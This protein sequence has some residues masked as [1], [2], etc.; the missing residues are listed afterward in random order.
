M[1][2]EENPS[3]IREPIL[4]VVLSLFFPGWGQL[5]NGKNW[6]A[7]KFFGAFWGVWLLT[8]IVFRILSYSIFTSILALVCIGIWGYGMYDAYKVADK[9]NKKQ[10]NFS[11]ASRFVWLPVIAAII[12]FVA[13][14]LIIYITLSLGYY[15]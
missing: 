15:K 9:I 1:I 14:F 10:E 8:Q 3:K 4:A 5:Y 7:L 12:I 6:D 13:T 11:G 2:I